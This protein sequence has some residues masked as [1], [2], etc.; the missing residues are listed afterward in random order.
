MM[1]D[2]R[3]EFLEDVVFFVIVVS[4]VVSFGRPDEDRA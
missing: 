4:V 3:R 1:D 2:L